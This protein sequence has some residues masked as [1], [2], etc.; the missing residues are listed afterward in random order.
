M[1]QHCDECSIRASHLP[2]VTRCQIKTVG[3]HSPL[4]SVQLPLLRR[5]SV[6]EQPCIRE[7]HSFTPLLVY[8]CNSGGVQGLA[9]PPQA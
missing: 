5:A 7:G 1:T 2:K 4:F 6:R 9:P 3:P 8:S